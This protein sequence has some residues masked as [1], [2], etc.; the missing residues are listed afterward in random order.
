MTLHGI[1]SVND[2]LGELGVAD[3]IKVR[4]SHKVVPVNGTLSAKSVVLA[5]DL[6]RVKA[7]SKWPLVLH[8]GQELL[9]GVCGIGGDG[10]AQGGEVFDLECLGIIGLA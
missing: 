5:Y 10:Q 9:A 7:L 3:S 2:A 8:L 6:R 1:A 4:I